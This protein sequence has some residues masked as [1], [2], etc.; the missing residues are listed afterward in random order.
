[1]IRSVE[2]MGSIRYTEVGC[3]DGE[4]RMGSMIGYRGVRL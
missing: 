3:P 2:G 1:V 4:S